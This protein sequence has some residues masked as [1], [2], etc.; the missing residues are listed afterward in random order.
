MRSFDLVRGR[1]EDARGRMGQDK[2][3]KRD[4]SWDASWKDGTTH[5]GPAKKRAQKNTAP[6]TRDQ[7]QNQDDDAPGRRKKTTPSDRNLGTQR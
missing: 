7:D 1:Y 5:L 3:R 4:A 2:W 6:L